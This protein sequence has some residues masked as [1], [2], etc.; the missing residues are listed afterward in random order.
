MA[1]KYSSFDPTR[2]QMIRSMVAGSALLPAILR[3]C[4][5]VTGD[6]LAPKSPHFQPKA[7]RVI[8]INCS[9]GVSHMETFDPKPGLA[10]AAREHKKAKNGK[11]YLGPA[12][13]FKRESKCGTEV[14]DL[15]PWVRKSMDDVCMIR[16]M[17]GDH[18]D[19]AQ[20]TLGVHTGSVTFAR[21]SIGSWVSY[22]LGT[23]NRNLPSFV[24]VAP[25][26][27]YSG[28]QVW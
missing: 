15:F 9:G 22:G 11:P 19:H 5:A 24:V 23:E 27:P 2:R 13:E 12:W 4:L 6:D 1:S 10:A 20:A 28:A 14:S 21:P 16:S 17:H 25:A 7:R 8:F 3:D 26:L 18:Q